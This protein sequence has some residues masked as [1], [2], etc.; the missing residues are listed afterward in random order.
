MAHHYRL[1]VVYGSSFVE[2]F[3]GLVRIFLFSALPDCF[4]EVGAKM[5]WALI[6]FSKGIIIVNESQLP[7]E[8]IFKS[9]LYVLPSDRYAHGGL[10]VL[11]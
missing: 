4:E 1:A 7:H 8:G 6:L 3:A 9:R 11:S 2:S 10:L 5:F